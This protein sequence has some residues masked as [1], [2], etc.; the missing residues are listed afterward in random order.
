LHPGQHYQADATI[1]KDKTAEPVRMCCKRKGFSH[2]GHLSDVIWRRHGLIGKVFS[3][4]REACHM[5]NAISPFCVVFTAIFFLA[6]VSAVP[7]SAEQLQTIMP[8]SSTVKQDKKDQEET[9]VKKAKP[10]QSVETLIQEEH[11]LFNQRFTLETGISY[12]QFDRKQLALN[13]FIALD[14][15]FLGNISVDSVEAN[16]LTMD[17]T[18]R[19]GPVD[20]LQFDLNL[21]FLYRNTTYQSTDSNGGMVEEEIVMDPELGDVSAGIYWQLLKE[22]PGRPD[23]VWNIRGKA[24]SGSDP[25]GIETHDVPDTGLLNIPNELS[26]GNGVWGASTGLSFMKT[27]DPAILFANLGYFYN[28]REHFD[29]IVPTMAGNQPG[30]IDLGNSIQYSIGMAFALNEQLSMNMSYAHRFTGKSQTRL[31]GGGWTKIV[32]S[33]ANA[34]TM[35]FGVNCAVSNHLSMVTNVGIGLTADAP[36]MQFSLKFPYTY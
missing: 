19:Y 27:M 33:D 14:A 2:R 23:V 6:I 12:S 28:F 29:D 20:R 16:I 24:P 26:S 34:A 21:P 30:E 9:V 8:I 32:G 18:A 17:V 36:D 31:D 1:E 5:Q 7:V 15:I 3:V 13:G 25:Y 35:S 22:I 11:V 4:S 10:T